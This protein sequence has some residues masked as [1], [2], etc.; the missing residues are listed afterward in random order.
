MI[1]FIPV[2]IEVGVSFSAGVRYRAALEALKASAEVAPYIYSDAFAKFSLDAKI[3]KAGVG[4]NLTILDAELTI[5]GE[6]GLG[7]TPT[8]KTKIYCQFT[9]DLVLKA[10]SGRLY[11][12][13]DYW[14]IFQRK[15]KLS[16]YA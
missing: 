4:A 8:G 16:R 2:E 5:S 1:G 13:I 14:S 11:A 15:W 9:G 6:G 7:K 10:L 12:F 3:G